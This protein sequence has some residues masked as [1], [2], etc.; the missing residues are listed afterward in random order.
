MGLFG[1]NYNRPGPG[2]AKDAPPKK[3]VMRFF[4][5]LG[6]DYGALWRVGMVTMVCFLPLV[7]SAGILY[8]FRGYIIPMAIGLVLY[9]LSSM[10][11][12]MAVAAQ[13]AVTL[14]AV[15]DIPGFA[16]Q[17]YKKAWKDN[18]KQARRT[19]LVMFSLMGI[20]C[21]SVIYMLFVQGQLNVMILGMALLG[22]LLCVGCGM[23]CFAQMV[24][25]EMDLITMV[26]NSMFLMFGFLNRTLPGLLF[27]LVPYA[28][29]LLFVSVPLWPLFFL[30]GLHAVLLLVWGQW[31]WPVM[32]SAFHITERQKERDAQREAEAAEAA[33]SEP[34]QIDS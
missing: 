33:S 16:W 2:V 17:D 9:A 32:E 19:G 30:L 25:L 10:L 29:M 6:R 4:E 28:L 34:T 12:G 15:R 31:V 11:A 26:K 14:K 13:T 3:G 21:A 22:L 7:I 8:L 1:I 27:I 24:F 23:L 5:L 20:E 18:A